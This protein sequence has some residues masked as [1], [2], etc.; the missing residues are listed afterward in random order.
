MQEFY[1]SRPRNTYFKAKKYKFLIMKY[2]YRLQQG[3]DVI[4][5]IKVSQE[6]TLYTKM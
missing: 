5:C 1:I 4:S 2:T 3:E 6:N